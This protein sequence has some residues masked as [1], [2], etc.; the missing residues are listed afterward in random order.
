VIARRV[1]FRV[2]LVAAIAPLPGSAGGQLPRGVLTRS[3]DAGPG[4]LLAIDEGATGAWQKLLKVGTTAS[5][6]VT[7]AHPDDEE[8]G[9]LTMLS[10]GMGA[11]T[12]LLTLNRG[13]GGANAIGPELFDALGLIRTEELRLAGRYYG[14]DDQYFT[15]AVDYGFSKTLDEAMRSWEREAVLADMVRIIRMN[16]P[17]VV[18]SRWHGSERDGHGHHQAAGA[19][20]PEA[21]L[22][23]ADPAR[24]PDQITREGLRPWRAKKLYRGRIRDGETWS[25][26]L[27]PGTPSPW[28]GRSYQ[29]VGAEGLALQRSQTSGRSRPFMG[30]VVTRYERLLPAEGPAREQGLFDGL[31]LSIAGIFELLGEAPPPGAVPALE[32]VERHVEQARASFRM[33]DPGAAAE[34]LAGALAGLRAVLTRLPQNGEARFH[35]AI[36]ELEMVQALRALVGVRVSAI[37]VAAGAPAGSSLGPIVP[38]QA[39]DVHVTVQNA[40]RRP[41]S[42]GGAE[43]ASP[44]GRWRPVSGLVEGGTLR[45]GDV[46]TGVLH[47]T[48]PSDARPSRPWFGRSSIAETMYTVRDSASIHL[49]EGPSRLLVGGGL[50]VDGGPGIGMVPVGVAA[51]VHSLETDLPYGTSLAGL[52]VVPPVAL[53]VQPSLRVVRPGHAGPFQVVVEATSAAPGVTEAGVT[54]ELPPGWAASP[55]RADVRLPGAGASAPAHF[56]VTPPPGLAEPGRIAGVAEVDG[57]SYREQVY[58]VRHR[59]LETR[60]LYRP[61]EATVVP[62]DVALPKGLRVAYVMGVGDDVAAAIAQLGAAVTLLGEPDLASGDLSVFDAVVVGTRAYAVRRDLVAH[63]ARLLDYARSGGNLVV[64]YQ[65]PEFDP[66]TQAPLR[67]SLPGNAEEVSEEDAPVTLLAPGNPLLTEPNRITS[68]D[69]EG[70]IEQRGS[71]FLATWDDGYVPLLETHDT[72]QEPQRGVWLTA[73]VGS[74][75]YTFVALALHRQVPYGVPGAY[76]ILANLIAPHGAR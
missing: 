1:A 66:E 40:G 63:N 49:G 24:F 62:I 36:E 56:L 8:A 28:L 50:D 20:T 25:V 26:Q 48:V 14:L 74:G 58:V 43:L 21:V 15:T 47:V 18:I 64:L 61:A 52:T 7:T 76:R 30:A 19:L 27:D 57:R 59:D 16:R 3:G 55:A 68:A 67:A 70:W 4:G 75:R 17:L 39:L 46:A 2:A 31:D 11:R 32:E 6:L 9:V 71:K 73:Q 38:G 60:R 45:P 5:V 44:G 69:F 37:A 42:F 51:P 41:L 53:D 34:P 12:A 13:E 72:G 29:E 65:T 33:D 10:R 23:A 22:A 54:L 35:L